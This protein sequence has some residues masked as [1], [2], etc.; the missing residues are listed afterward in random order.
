MYKL[1]KDSIS[2]KVLVVNRLLDNAFIP[3]DPANTDYQRFKEQVLA[4]AELQDAD[5]N[6]MTQEQ[7][8]EF[9]GSLP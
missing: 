1:I 7:V 4:G 9:I 6:V 2:N 3:F 8:N 5:G